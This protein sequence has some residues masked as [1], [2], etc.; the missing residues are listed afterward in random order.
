MV[1]GSLYEAGTLSHLEI[2][3]LFVC[4]LSDILGSQGGIMAVFW[5]VAP[6]SAVGVSRRFRGAATSIISARKT[7]FFLFIY[8]FPYQHLRAQYFTVICRVNDLNLFT[9]RLHDIQV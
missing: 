8:L 3:C 6:S 2:D 1:T 4:L 5:V 9:T 7:D